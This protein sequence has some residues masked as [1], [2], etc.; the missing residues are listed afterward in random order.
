MSGDRGVWSDFD[1]NDCDFD[2]HHRVYEY[3]VHHNPRNH[4]QQHMDDAGNWSFA[5]IMGRLQ[6]RNNPKPIQ[7]PSINLN[8]NTLEV[9][10]VRS[11]TITVMYN[12]I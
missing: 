3:L 8:G 7:Y 12:D 9:S 6:F 11:M 2:C 1:P 10:G 4:M 5:L